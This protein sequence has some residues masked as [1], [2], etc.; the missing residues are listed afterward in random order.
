M[1]FYDSHSVQ[2]HMQDGTFQAF[3]QFGALHV[4]NHQ[5]KHPAMPELQQ[6]STA[7]LNESPRKAIRIGLLNPMTSNLKKYTSKYKS[8]TIAFSNVLNMFSYFIISL[9]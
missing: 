5:N 9:L 1:A 3:K 8:T 6:E 7:H 4:H 2:Y